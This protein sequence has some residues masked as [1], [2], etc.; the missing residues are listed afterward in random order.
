MEIN[1]DDTIKAMAK[2]ER[3]VMP[4][5]FRIRINDLADSLPRWQKRAKSPRMRAARI[6]ALTTAIC[7]LTGGTVLAQTN[8][9][10]T[11]N[12]NGLPGELTIEEISDAG[13]SAPE[14]GRTDY[15][16]LEETL[17]KN[18]MFRVTNTFGAESTLLQMEVTPEQLEKLLT[19]SVIP[20][21]MPQEVPEGY[22]FDRGWIYFGLSPDLVS[23]E[24]KPAYT[25]RLEDGRLFEVFSLPNGYEQYINYIFVAYRNEAGSELQFIAQPLEKGAIV[26][27]AARETGEIEETELPGYSKAVYLHDG[28]GETWNDMVCAQKEIPETPYLDIY[29]LDYENTA[30]GKSG[31]PFEQKY[32]DAVLYSVTGRDIGEETLTDILDGL[33]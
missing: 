13:A 17:G 29:D 4:K 6:A 10:L 12:W 32:Y 22:R 27:F 15:S 18:E 1:F 21:E 19:D 31:I 33:K 9:W 11:F 5:D 14:A 25:E 28:F 3:A 7:L 24:T 2:K 16:R 30:K 20:Y 8:G 23:P 26:S